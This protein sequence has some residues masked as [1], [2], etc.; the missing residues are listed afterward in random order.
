M[1]RRIHFHSPL[2]LLVIPLSVS[3]LWPVFPSE[4]SGS[5]PEAALSYR[6]EERGEVWENA[7]LLLLVTSPS[8]APPHR[9]GSAH[10][11]VIGWQVSVTE[12]RSTV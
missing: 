9:G 6:E 2:R 12:F 8:A 10:R 5:D 7:L 1:C 11:H 3:C 4:A